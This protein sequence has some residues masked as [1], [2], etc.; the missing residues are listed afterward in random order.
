MMFVR[1]LLIVT[2]ATPALG[3]QQVNPFAPTPN[4]LRRYTECMQLARREPLKALPMAE[5]WKAEGG[6]LGARHCVAVALYETGRFVP[7]ATQLEVIERDMGGERPGL[8]AELLAQA[9]Q[10][11]MEANQAENAAAAQSRAIDLKPGDPELW[12]DRGLSYA[13]MRAWP[14]AI[15]DFERSLRLAPDNVETM[16]LLAAAWRNAGDPARAQAEA[17]R[18]L[19]RAPEHSQALLERGFALLA[20]GERQAAND[21]FNRVLKLVPGTD[22]ARRAEAGLRGEPPGPAASRPATAPKR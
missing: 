15:S 17:E 4:H 13:A 16:V 2:L 18:A 5:K 22:E 19:R 12:V 14:R 9:G 6:G 3:Q 10:A 11:W 20:R 7:A 1:V 8:R 21:D